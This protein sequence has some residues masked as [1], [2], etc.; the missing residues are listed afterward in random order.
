M[1]DQADQSLM[2]FEEKVKEDQ[3]IFSEFGS[4]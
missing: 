2:F 3:A 4:I 1:A